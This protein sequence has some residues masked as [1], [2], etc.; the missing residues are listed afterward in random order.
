MTRKSIL[1]VF[2]ALVAVASFAQTAKRKLT[3]DDIY[4]RDKR[5]T[6]ATSTSVPSSF[7]WV[8]DTHFFFSRKAGDETQFLL[9]NVIT[10]E[11]VA[12]FD[13]GELQS[14]IGRLEGMST[15]R[16]RA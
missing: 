14:T 10:G 12:L 8:D 3:L 13:A 16:R 15:R 7:T 4:D 1:S 5:L 9:T 11:Q 2:I 6:I